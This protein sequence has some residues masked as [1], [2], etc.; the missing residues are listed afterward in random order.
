MI[1]RALLN[2]SGVG[3]DAK[4]FHTPQEMILLGRGRVVLMLVAT[5]ALVR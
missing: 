4:V 5:V 1:I 3:H 2:Y